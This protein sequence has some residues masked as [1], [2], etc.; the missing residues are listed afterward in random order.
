MTILYFIY[1]LGLEEVEKTGHFECLLFLCGWIHL[2]LSFLEM[3]TTKLLLT[4]CGTLFLDVF[5]LTSSKSV[6][7]ET[8]WQVTDMPHGVTSH[9]SFSLLF[10][11]FAV[12]FRHITLWKYCILRKICAHSQNLDV[13]YGS[14]ITASV[15]QWWGEEKK[16]CGWL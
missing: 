4:L 10:S 9:T 6:G 7:A 12:S 13:H 3:L 2:S 15:F 1:L 11:K 5:K 16:T 8:V 14:G